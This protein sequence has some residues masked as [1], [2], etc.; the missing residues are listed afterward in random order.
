MAPGQVTLNTPLS[1]QELDELENLLLETDLD[2]AMGI[3]MLDGYFAALLSGPTTIMPREWMRWVWDVEKGEDSPEF[4]NARQAQRVMDLMMRHMNDVTTT[5][6]TEPE[7]YD[8][9]LMQSPGDPPIPLIDD[10]CTGFM[11]GVSLDA[12]GWLPV[13]AGHPDWM[14]TILL[15]GTEEGFEVLERNK[16]SL[17]EHRALAAG[18]GDTVRTIHAHFLEGRKARA[19]AGESGFPGREPVR[20]PAKIGRNERC[21][22]GSGKKYKHCHGGSGQ[23]LH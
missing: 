23:L 17:D 13:T 2:E 21:P 11:K 16:P 3:A 22:C 4:A 7:Y 8:P 9:V 12:E 6:L 18:I 1:D 5:L 15:Y 14:S 20:S 10:W 19:G